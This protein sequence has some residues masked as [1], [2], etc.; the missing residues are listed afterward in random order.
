MGIFFQNNQ[1]LTNAGDGNF[2][3]AVDLPN[4]LMNTSSVVIGDVNSDCLL[5][6]IIGN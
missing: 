6:I 3:N 1:L 2:S 4:G 5:D